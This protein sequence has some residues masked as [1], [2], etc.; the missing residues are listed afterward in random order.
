MAEALS[1][2]NVNSNNYFA[3]VG[4]VYIYICF[5]LGSKPYAAYPGSCNL[6]TIPLT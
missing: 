6:D 4:Q 5:N 2:E 3:S 1:L